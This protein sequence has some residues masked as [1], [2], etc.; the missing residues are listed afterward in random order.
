MKQHD[1]FDD[2]PQSEA[3][4]QIQMK[5]GNRRKRKG[6]ATTDLFSD[7]PSSL[8]LDTNYATHSALKWIESDPALDAVCTTLARRSRRRQRSLPVTVESEATSLALLGTDLCSIVVREA[9]RIEHSGLFFEL[10]LEGSRD[11]R[12]TELAEYFLAKSRKRT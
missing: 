1:L 5:G 8:I 7:P 4:D 2:F 12:W 9:I 6:I 10:F 3:D 11:I